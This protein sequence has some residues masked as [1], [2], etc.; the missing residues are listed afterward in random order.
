M[1]PITETS[2]TAARNMEAALL[3]KSKKELTSVYG[4]ACLGRISDAKGAGL[5]KA[6][7]AY[8]ICRARFGKKVA[9]AA[10]L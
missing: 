6:Q 9:E 2:M 10:L 7:M 3:R 8:D 5:T 1:N 4:R